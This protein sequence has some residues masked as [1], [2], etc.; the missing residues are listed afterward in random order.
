MEKSHWSHGVTLRSEARSAS[1]ARGFVRDTLVLHELPAMVDDIRLVVSELAAVVIANRGDDSLTVTIRRAGEA[2]VLIVR[3]GSVSEEV[4][5]LVSDFDTDFADPLFA[6][7]RGL[8]DGHGVEDFMYN[9]GPAVWATFGA[10][11]QA[12]P[13]R[14]APLGAARGVSSP[15]VPSPP[16]EGGAF[17]RPSVP[18][19]PSG[20]GVERPKPECGP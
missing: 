14:R 9:G 4:E 12:P 16:L 13:L 6:S 15:P 7:T 5:M 1:R 20:K 10:P 3:E 2:V 17:S 11:G 18:L 19:P 8:S